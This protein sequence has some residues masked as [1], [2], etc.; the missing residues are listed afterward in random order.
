V[1]QPQGASL[2]ARTLGGI[3]DPEGQSFANG[4]QP[5]SRIEVLG[6]SVQNTFLLL[7]TVGV[8]IWSGGR[9]I[10]GDRENGIGN[11][12]N[13]HC[14]LPSGGQREEQA[15]YGSMRNRTYSRGADRGLRWRSAL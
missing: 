4:G 7:E 2:K 8:W 11:V 6:F 13:T 3:T 12:G 15:L 1:L 14:G 5:G 9:P 10:D